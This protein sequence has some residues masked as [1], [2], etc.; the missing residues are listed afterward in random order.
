MFSPTIVPAIGKYTGSAGDAQGQGSAIRSTCNPH[1]KIASAAEHPEIKLEQLADA[2]A[3]SNAAPPRLVRWVAGIRASVHTKLLAAF[4]VVTLLFIAM[5]LVSLQTI[6]N[7]TRQSQLAR[8]GARAGQP[9]PSRAS[10]RWPGRCTYTD[11]ALLS[12]DEVA[13]AKILREN[14]RFNDLLAKLEAA[15]TADR[16]SGRADP[17]VAGRGD[18]GRG[19]HGQRDPR[20]QARRRRPASCCAARSGSTSE[21]TDARGPTRR[22]AAGPNDAAARQRH[23]RQPQV[24]DPDQRVRGDRGGARAA[25]RFRDLL[26]LHPS[27]ARGAGASWTR[28]R[29]AISAGRISVPNRD[30]FGVLADRM[31]HMSQELQR[32]DTEQRVAAAEL[33]R[34]NRATGADRARRSP[35]FSPT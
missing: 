14:N 5:A 35:S 3:E 24:A 10:T 12:Q 18:G 2:G 9:G 33:V 7:T 16:G 8:R 32:F 31:N 6:V 4:L 17:I 27:G 11:L 1:S 22:G 30:E 34:L 21:I 26:V 19:R 29:R 15:G 28:W 20:R 25:L 13:I 23:R